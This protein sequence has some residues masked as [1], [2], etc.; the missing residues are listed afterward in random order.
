MSP[1][2]IE[3]SCRVMHDAYRLAQPVIG[4]P[5]RDRAGVVVAVAIVDH[6]DGDHLGDGRW[7]L[8]ASGYAARETGY[9]HRHLL[10]LEVGSLDEGDHLNGDPLDNRR[11]NLRVATRQQNAQNV[12]RPNA[13]G[14]RG[15][16]ILPNG[17]YRA[18][19]SVGG[20]QTHL[21]VFDASEDAA[22]AAL[23]WRAANHDEPVDRSAVPPLA[24][25]ARATLLP[26]EEV[27]EANKA[28]MRVAVGALLAHQEREGMVAEW[29]VRFPSGTVEVMASESE[30]RRFGLNANGLRPDLPTTVVRHV[31][32]DWTPVTEADQ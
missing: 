9:L 17:R 24:P 4:V 26:W 14:Y 28:T 1:E 2:T 6:V 31:V 23:R 7:Y 12:E 19:G 29:G 20:R 3:E 22:E 13:T 5:L 32:T 15:V 18:Y 8:N 16:T 30:A 25:L 21:G 11:V 27:P 10:N